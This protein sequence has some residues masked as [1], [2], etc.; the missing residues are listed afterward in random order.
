MKK[1]KF[2]NNE[3]DNGRNITISYNNRTTNIATSNTYYICWCKNCLNINNSA[4]SYGML[5]KRI[6]NFSKK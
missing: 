1:C 3:F 6:I 5:S 2:C 4:S